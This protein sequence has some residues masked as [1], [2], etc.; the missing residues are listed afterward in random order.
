MLEVNHILGK[1]PHISN[2]LAVVL[3]LAEVQPIYKGGLDA[4][5]T[6]ED[7]WKTLNVD[8]R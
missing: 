7:F 1:F 5:K 6:P 8:R 2:A 3:A 4:S